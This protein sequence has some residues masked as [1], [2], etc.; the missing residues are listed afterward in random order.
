M[1]RR[2]CKG[3]LW[4]WEN[5][6][7]GLVPG[8]CYNPESPRYHQEAVGGCDCFVAAVKEEKWRFM[9]N[10]HAIRTVKVLHNKKVV[11]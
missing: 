1:R 11:R 6:P 7:E 2:K 10:P 9:Y 5:V 4:D 8:W 3:C